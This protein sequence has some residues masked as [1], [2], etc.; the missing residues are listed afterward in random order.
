MLLAAN[1]ASIWILTLICAQRFQSICEPWNAW[2][3]RLQIVRNSKT[4]I[5]LVIILAIGNHFLTS[6]VFYII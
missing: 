3:K 5:A 2:K 1:Y 4:P 6:T